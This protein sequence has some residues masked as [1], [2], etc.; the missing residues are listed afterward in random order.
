MKKYMTFPK[1]TMAVL[2]LLSGIVLCF[3]NFDFIDMMYKKPKQFVENTLPE[4]VQSWDT[5][6]I[7][8]KTIDV[9]KNRIENYCTDVGNFFGSCSVDHLKWLR[10]RLFQGIWHSS[11]VA[12]LKCQNKNAVF[13]L[14]IVPYQ[15]TYKYDYFKIFER[16][17]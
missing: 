4:M 17:K 10:S 12:D 1:I 11:F 16:I 13:Y 14:D 3:G 5:E 6:V 9:E 2:L 8:P 7:Y 15:D